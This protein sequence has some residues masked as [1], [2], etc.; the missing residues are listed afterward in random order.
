[1]VDLKK[2]CCY[3]CKFGVKRGSLAR[4]DESDLKIKRFICAKFPEYLSL[5]RAS[6]RNVDDYPQHTWCGF[7]EL[8]NSN[9]KAAKPEEVLKV[10][11]DS[12]VDNSD[13]NSK[14]SKPTRK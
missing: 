7:F 9:V 11:E 3:L 12:V 8:D 10:D 4:L 14:T 6:K 13:L 5:D 2:E 1:M